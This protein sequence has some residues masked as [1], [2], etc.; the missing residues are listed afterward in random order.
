[1]LGQDTRRHVSRAA[2]REWHDH[3]DL[4]RR[5]GLCPCNTRYRQRGSARGQMQKISAGKFHGI[6]S[7]KRRRRDALHS[8]LILAARITLPHFSV[9]SVISLPNW[10]GDPGSGVPPRS[11][12]R[13]FILG[14]S[15][16]ALTSLL[17]L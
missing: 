3:G 1:M 5:I 10:T 12:R 11:A 4:A 2:R 8:A 6:P 9:S 7:L 14:S 13:A 15:K 17:S 16:A